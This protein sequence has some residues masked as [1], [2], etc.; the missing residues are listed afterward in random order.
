MLRSPVH[1]P[2]LA[3]SIARDIVT[4]CSAE[5]LSYDT[6]DYLTEVL[7]LLLSQYFEQ[8]WPA[9]GAGLLGKD[10]RFAYTLMFINGGMGRKEETGKILAASPL[11]S[12]L[13]WCEQNRP[14]GPRVVARMLPV[15]AR[16]GDNGYTW[17]PFARAFLEAFGDD[18]EFL[19]NIAGNLHSFFWTGS[20]VPYY[21]MQIHLMDELSCHKHPQVQKWARDNTEWLKKQISQERRQEEEHDLGI[22]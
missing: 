17:H 4:A 11:P 22:Y 16:S 12:L 5:N 6:K 9:I 13:S 18:E 19:R 21:E 10:V 2:E 7:K 3:I 20:V 1:D 14:E 8:V 15:I